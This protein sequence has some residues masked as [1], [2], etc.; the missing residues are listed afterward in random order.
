MIDKARYVPSFLVEKS[1]S[2]TLRR[3]NSCRGFRLLNIFYLE[4]QKIR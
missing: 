4:N 3:K 1:A 2:G